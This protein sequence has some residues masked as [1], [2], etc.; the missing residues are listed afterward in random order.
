MKKKPVSRTVL[1]N[2]K[3]HTLIVQLRKGQKHIHL[4]IDSDGTI[5]ISAP[6]GTTQARLDDVIRKKCGWLEARME[7]VRTA[8][9]Q[10]D[11]LKRIPFCGEWYSVCHVPS[12]MKGTVRLSGNDKLLSIHAEN[13]DPH[14]LLQ[15][16]KRYMKNTARKVLFEKV[17]IWS[18]TLKVP[19]ES[20]SIRDQK[21][22]WGSS[23]GRGH[24]S[25][26][27]RTL[28]TPDQIQDY[29]VVHEL[30]HQVH[31]NHSASY[32]KAVCEAYPRSRECDRW[33][34]Q[35]DFIMGILR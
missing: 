2:G 3:Q 12:T 24:I 28:C 9:R 19:Y 33:L 8:A 32:W 27:W 20:I 16:L 34:K 31:H 25:L 26:N 29:L 14:Y 10:Y 6:A 11:P 18:E 23:S 17:R 4:R 21:S 15:V 5:R 1:F 30:L 13:G 22:R 7:K 35:H